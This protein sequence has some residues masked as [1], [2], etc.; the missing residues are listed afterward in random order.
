ME[1]P[2]RKS[3]FIFSCQI[4]LGAFLLYLFPIDKYAT[5]PMAPIF[6]L[7]G[8]IAYGI[9]LSWGLLGR[10]PRNPFEFCPN[11]EKK[12]HIQFLQVKKS[13]ELIG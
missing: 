3:L 9:F 6:Y 2:S 10:R 8:V 12:I 5:Y 11:C 13:V 1:W 4:A 7:I